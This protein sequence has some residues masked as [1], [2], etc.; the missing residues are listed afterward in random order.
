MIH[1]FKDFTFKSIKAEFTRLSFK[2]KCI[3]PIRV[4][5]LF[6]L[7]FIIFLS[8]FINDCL[9]DIFNFV[10]TFLDTNQ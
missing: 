3:V 5:V 7:V 8:N 4:V 6:P 2:G 9:N 10:D 1:F